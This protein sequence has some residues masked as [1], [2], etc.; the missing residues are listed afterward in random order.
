[1]ILVTGSAGY[2]GSQI[3]E[4][5]EKNNIN[6]IGIDNFLYS[7]PGNI[8]NKKR[9]IKTDFKDSKKITKI[10]KKFNID[11]IIHCAAAS[12][13]LEGEFKK[14]KYI[15]NNY[16]N[17]IIFINVCKKNFVKNFIF[18]S[19]SN[20]YSENIKNNYFS[21]SSKTKPK[22]YYGKTKLIIEKYLLSKKKF[23]KN[24][25]ILR[26]FNIIGLTK[27]FKPKKFYQFKHQRF[28]FKIH[29]MIKKKEPMFLNYIDGKNKT[30][31]YP[32]RDF[33]DIRDFSNI[34]LFIL[35]NLNKKFIKIYNAG[36]GKSY[37]LNK[38]LNLMK[39]S[40]NSNF[41]LKYTKLPKKEYILTRAS[42]KKINS[43]LKWKPK[44]L[45]LDSIKSLKKNLII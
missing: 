29:Y 26:L 4:Y 36:C 13:V 44:F 19:S 31:I 18:L 8:T 23:F 5:F 39:S 11:T 25:Y 24:I 10:I 17:T 12:Y 22:N 3:T 42:I 27:K 28:F 6:Y 40:E 35:K 20:V 37:A 38:I 15:K 7:I 34:I 32:S 43:E 45:I 2:I 21:E 30:R 16:K 33:L 41:K 14:K 1:M 9:F